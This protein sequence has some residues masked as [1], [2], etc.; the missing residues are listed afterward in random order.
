M[1]QENYTYFP[2]PLFSYKSRRSLFQL[3]LIAL[4]SL[5]VISVNKAGQLSNILSFQRIDRASANALAILPQLTSFDKAIYLPL[6]NLGAS[7]YYVAP[8]GDD[9]NPGTLA[10]PW[11]SI[12][13]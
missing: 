1:L 7:I 3:F 12:Q 2:R 4:L 8:D 11:R 5:S 13:K 6:I 9:S 10:K